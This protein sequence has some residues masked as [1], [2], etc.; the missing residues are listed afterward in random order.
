MDLS[1]NESLRSKGQQQ[2]G[3]NNGDASAVTTT[4]NSNNKT[5]N[6]K[7]RA[8]TGTDE[9]NGLK[10]DEPIRDKDGRSWIRDDCLEFYRNKLL[11]LPISSDSTSSSSN[12]TKEQLSPKRPL[13]C[14]QERVGLLRLGIDKAMGMKKRFPNAQFLE[15][16]VHEGKDLVRMA[17]FLRSIEK[18]NFTRS[19]KKNSNTDIDIDIDIDTE[20]SYT[21]L[22]GFDSFEGLPEDWINGQIGTDDKPYHKQGAFDTGGEPPDVE[23]LVDHSLKLRYHKRTNRTAVAVAAPPKCV[24]NIE[25]HKGWFHESLPP[26]LDDHDGT[27]VAFVHADADLYTSTLTFLR[28]ICSRR[29]FRK[30]SVIVFDEFW[31][32]PNWENGEHKAWYEIVAEFGLESKY[33]YFGYHA[34]HPTKPFKHYGYQ[35]VGVV[36]TSDMD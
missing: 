13:I 2:C 18:R 16:G 19:Q 14:V 28:L 22:H 20:P 32:Y 29:L 31:N 12:H 11:Q 33:E 36:L 3:D 10:L 1:E 4:R 9:E 30:G 24:D 27:P 7:D 23:S 34:P 21:T 8:S 17:V 35:S 25:F 15:F 5:N 26:F 6:G